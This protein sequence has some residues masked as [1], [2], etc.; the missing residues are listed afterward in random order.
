MLNFSAVMKLSGVFISVPLLLKMVTFVFWMSSFDIASLLDLHRRVGK[1]FAGYFKSVR[2]CFNAWEIASA[3][4]FVVNWVVSS[5]WIRIKINVF[6][7][8]SL[9]S[10]VVW[11]SLNQ[12]YQDLYRNAKDAFL[13]ECGKFAH[14]DANQ[15]E[16]VYEITCLFCFAN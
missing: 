16:S 13:D 2:S 9:S 11:L 3:C 1:V 4:K 7:I 6:Q 14:N 15:L 8:N 12:F 10:G 5:L